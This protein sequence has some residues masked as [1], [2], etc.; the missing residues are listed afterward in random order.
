MEESVVFAKK[1]LEDILSFYG[2]NTDVHATHDE[3][4]IELAIPSTH[5]NGFLIGQQGDTM[6]ALQYMVSNTLKCKGF[7]LTRVNVDVADY[8]K[9]RDERLAEQVKLWAAEVKKTGDAKE[10]KPMSSAER[11]VVHQVAT[12]FG[13]ETESIGEGRERRVV[14]MPTDVV[15]AEE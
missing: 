13:L 11:R 3:D 2:L 14:L 7:E 15:V 9:Q 4:I 8:K 1:Y 6:R 12:E 5:M 10:L